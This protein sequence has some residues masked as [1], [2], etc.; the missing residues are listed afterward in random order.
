MRKATFITCPV[1]Y[2]EF[3]SLGYARHRAMHY[4]ERERKLREKNIK[5]TINK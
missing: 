1:C 5:T 4:D 2:K 3:K